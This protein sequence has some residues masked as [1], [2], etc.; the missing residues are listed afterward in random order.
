MIKCEKISFSYTEHSPSVL[1]EV[2]FSIQE[3]ETVSIM[4][5]NGSGK[6]SLARCLNGLLQP[7]AGDVWVD[8]LNTKLPGE[9]DAIRKKVGM[10]FQNPDNQIVGTTVEREIA[11][12]MENLRFPR[13]KMHATVKQL[14][15]DFGL[16][17]LKNHPP[18]KLSG[19]EKQLLCMAAVLAMNP[20]YFILDE[21]TSLLDPHSRRLI[22]ES[23]FKIESNTT[24][25]PT[26]I[27]ITQYP[28]EALYTHRLMILSDGKIV[29]DGSPREIFKEADEL[30]GLGIGVP[31]E[32][33][34]GVEIDLHEH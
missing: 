17:G 5:A 10:V 2:S 21:P 28:E 16:A 18:H 26:P 14:L 34:L 4:G 6:S 3:G 25:S 30:C 31:I 15:Q 9:N 11:F 8:G 27:L 1:N 19:G 29:R 22:L 33:A 7:S 23:L 20:Q 24:E 13:E 32:Y 12:G